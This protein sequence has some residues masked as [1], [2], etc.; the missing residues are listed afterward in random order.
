MVQSV[1]VLWAV[2]G[3]RVVICETN[4]IVMCM[5]S[6]MAMKFVEPMLVICLE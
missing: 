2:L 5:G 3:V 1:T 6:E 4:C